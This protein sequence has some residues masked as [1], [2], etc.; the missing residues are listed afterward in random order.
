MRWLHAIH[1]KGIIK[2][3]GVFSKLMILVIGRHRVV[4]NLGAVIILV[5]IGGHSW[6][7]TRIRLILS[8]S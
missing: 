5:S 8:A 1:E 6:I 7:A 4:D 2:L 3:T